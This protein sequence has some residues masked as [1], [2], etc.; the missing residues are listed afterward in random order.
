MS[1]IR[2]CGIL[3]IGGVKKF[4]DVNQFGSFIANL[5]K[6]IKFR[7]VFILGILTRSE[8]FVQRLSISDLGL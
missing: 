8:S 5:S 1:A 3:L 2:L 4:S 7:S 6:K